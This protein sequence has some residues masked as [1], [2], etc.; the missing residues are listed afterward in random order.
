MVGGAGIDLFVFGEDDAVL[1]FSVG[2]D[3]VIISG[4]GVTAADFFDRVEIQQEGRGTKVIVDGDTMILHN[5]AF[6]SVS[7]ESFLLAA[8]QPEASIITSDVTLV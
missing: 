7:I 6:N 8:V 3:K 4:L 5:V 1:D 2:Q